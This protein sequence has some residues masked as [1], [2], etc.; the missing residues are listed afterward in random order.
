[1]RAAILVLLGLMVSRGSSA[2]TA[3]ERLERARV[4]HAALDFECAEKELAAIPLDALPE[5]ERVEALRLHAEACLA[6]GREEEAVGHIVAILGLRPSF[7][8]AWP[9]TWTRVFERARGLVPDRL[10]PVIKAVEVGKAMEG[11][12]LEVR[13]Y[14]E[15]PSGVSTVSLVVPGRPPLQLKSEDGHLWVGTVPAEWVKPPDLAYMVEA[16]DA[17]GNGPARLFSPANPKK[18]PVAPREVPLVRR[19][20]F[21]G[22]IAAGAVAVGTGIYFL[23]RKEGTA[24]ATGSGRGDVR[25]EVQWPGSFVS[26]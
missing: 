21:W 19:P 16:F 25:V 23:V 14:V 20:W 15:D 8:P 18:V 17:A 24:P 13:A 11:K 26:R 7:S 12:P 2:Q 6:L 1:V 4:C 10:P 3:Q 9:P 5:G 22:A